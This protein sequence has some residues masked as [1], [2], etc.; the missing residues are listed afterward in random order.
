MRRRMYALLAAFVLA[1]FGVVVLVQYVRG[2]DERAQAGEALVPVYVVTA[3]VPAGATA[4]SVA[5]S[6]SLEQVPSRL[7][8]AQALQDADAVAALG[9]KVADT[10]L[11]PGEQLLGSRFVDP[12]VL[13]PPDTVAAPVGTQEVSLTLDPQRAVSGHLAAGDL[14]GVYV[15]APIIDPETDETA[16]GNAVRLD[17]VLVTRVTQAAASAGATGQTAQ[18]V[19]VTV[20]VSATD[21]AKLIAGQE[22]NAVWL[23]L[24]VP[25]PAS[26]TL[27][28]SST[29]ADK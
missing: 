18:S 26:T 27:T 29:G 6:V 4:A 10:A 24:Q 5:S 21:A 19:D 22:Q 1:A 15:T 20:A 12:T 16:A 23:S 25:G 14:I 8:A 17:G 3:D 2:A 11:H 28:T 9:D 13:L 7:L